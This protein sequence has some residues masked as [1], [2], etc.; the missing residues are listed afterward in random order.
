M[1]LAAEETGFIKK[2]LKQAME[3]KLL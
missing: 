1:V 2:V 3:K